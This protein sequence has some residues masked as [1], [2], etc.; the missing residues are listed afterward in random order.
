MKGRRPFATRMKIAFA[1]AA[2]LLGLGVT[3][4]GLDTLPK[5]PGTD[6]QKVTTFQ[7]ADGAYGYNISPLD[8]MW[9]ATLS[10]KGTDALAG[11][12]VKAADAGDS[13]R[14]RA[15]IEAGM[16]PGSAGAQD[17]LEA[18][19]LRGHTDVVKVL[20]QAGTDAGA[21]DG[22]ALVAALR[23]G[24]NALAYDFL[25]KGVSGAAKNSAGLSIAAL[26]GNA[27][28]VDALI[29]AG[30]DAKADSSAALRYASFM[31]D[32]GIISALVGAGAEVGANDHEAVRQ[33]AESGKLEALQILV[34]AGGDVGASSGAALVAAST[35]GHSDVVKFILDQKKT[36]AGG[37]DVMEPGVPAGGYTVP[38]VYPN[39]GN[40]SALVMA[41]EGGHIETARI[42]LDAGASPNAG[43]GSALT[44][45]VF[46]NNYLMAHMLLSNGAD[47]N[48][49]NALHMAVSMDN[50]MMAQFLMLNKAVP[51]AKTKALGEQS[52]N[53]E[54]KEVLNG[55]TIP[56]LDPWYGF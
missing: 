20:L 51:D 46:N 15:L 40:G 54:L 19:A 12:A 43:D 48:T 9:K 26:N 32:T 41:V 8:Q 37:Y 35:Y 50:A 21:N 11:D 53:A 24:H 2:A 6:T 49:G 56:H 42:L 30:A 5:D 16:G 3:T 36:Y 7:G 25:A 45:A 52:K 34:K 23:G 17:A 10:L 28:M 31:G 55:K 33:A 18:A 27:E 47:P 38:A 44:T 13:W 14:I 4:G 1:S 39:V 22:A 29:A